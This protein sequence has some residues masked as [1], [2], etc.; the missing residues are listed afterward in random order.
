M[1]APGL[2][3]WS[4]DFVEHLRAVHFAL[5]VVSLILISAENSPDANHDDPRRPIALKQIEEIATF[6]KN[7]AK[8][9]RMVYAGAMRDNDLPDHWRFRMKIVIPREYYAKRVIETDVDI[10]VETLDAPGDWRFEDLTLPQNL[11]TLSEFEQ[12]WNRLH[13]GATLLLPINP[14]GGSECL[15]HVEVTR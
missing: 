11:T 13:E 10:P 1:S 4:K 6:E 15:Q 14:R 9:P 2:F 3:H 5:V 12:L 7:W 8:V